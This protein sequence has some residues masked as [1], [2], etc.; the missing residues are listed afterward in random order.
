VRQA[1]LRVRRR[2][3]AKG[4][5]HL[6]HVGGSRGR[7]LDDLSPRRGPRDARGAIR[8]P[9]AAAPGAHRGSDRQGVGP[10]AGG[11]D[12][13]RGCRE[14]PARRSRPGMHGHRDH[15]RRELRRRRARP[16]HAVRAAAHLQTRRYRR[17]PRGARAGR[18]APGARGGVGAGARAGGLAAPGGGNRRAHPAAGGALRPDR[19]GV[20]YQGVLHRPGD[21]G[22]T[23][24]PR[25]RQLEAGRSDVRGRPRPRD[26]GHHPRRQDRGSREQRGVVGA[27][28][29]VRRARDAAA[30][31]RARRGGRRLPARTLDLPFPLEQ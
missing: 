11:A 29:T 10:A 15:G 27:L 16:R 28:G 20:V 9:P 2:A 6:R 26:L 22:A 12:G 31:S 5:D 13:G 23:P 1:R 14:G 7:G 25:P 18:R 21:R 30:R 19:R 4:D 3:H 24:L 8:P 17:V